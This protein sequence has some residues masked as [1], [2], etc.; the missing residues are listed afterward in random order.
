M[1][2]HNDQEQRRNRSEIRIK[3]GVYGLVEKPAFQKLD[4][5]DKNGEIEE[6]NRR[7]P[8]SF[9]QYGSVYKGPFSQLRHVGI[10]G[11]GPRI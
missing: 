4:R 10:L 2:L 7:K 11:N 6:R 1:G 5:T 9:S 8:N 3:S